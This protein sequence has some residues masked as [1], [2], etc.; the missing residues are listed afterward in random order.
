VRPKSATEY[1]LPGEETEIELQ[2]VSVYG[3]VRDFLVLRTTIS[4]VR[5]AFRDLRAN[6]YCRSMNS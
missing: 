3:T 5:H 1:T 4:T 6:I 2:R